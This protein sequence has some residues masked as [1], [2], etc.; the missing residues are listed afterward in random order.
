VAAEPITVTQTLE[1]WLNSREAQPSA[2]TTDR[3]RV[4]IK[5]VE[6][7]LRQM[8]VTRLQPHHIEDLSSE[9]VAKGQSGSSI[10]KIHWALRR[11]SLTWAHRRRYYSV[12]ATDGIELSP[13]GAREMDQPSSA[14]LRRVIDYLLAK[15]FNW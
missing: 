6:P 8:G 15:D 9:L 13:L 4:A 2:A 3:Y 5:H 7:V 14:D 11:R 10:R 1:K 12:I